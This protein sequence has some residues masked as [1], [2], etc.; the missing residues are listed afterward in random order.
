MREL[1]WEDL[2]LLD[3]IV[4]AGTIADAARDLGVAPSTLYRRMAALEAAVGQ[5]CI[6]RG[7]GVVALTDAGRALAKVAQHTRRGLLE[8]EGALRARE[9]AVA[10]EVSLTTVESLLPYLA[11]PIAA[12]TARHPITV[13]LS[14]TDRGPSVRDREVDCAIAIVKRPPPSCWGRRLCRLPYGVFG[15]AEA[16]ARQPERLWVTREEAERSSPESAWERAHAGRVVARAKFSAVVDLAA[17]GV[18]VALLPRLLAGM[19]GTLVEAPEHRAS[20]EPL[21]RTAWILTHED[22]RRTPRIAA[23][24]DALTRHFEELREA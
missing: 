6:V 10:G 17:M 5:S 8:V 19:K 4:R 21:T 14:L 16:L 24:V 7:D 15:T 20:V 12:L 11:G 13:T 3:A 23:L 9:T 1:H 18:G 2:R 22:Q